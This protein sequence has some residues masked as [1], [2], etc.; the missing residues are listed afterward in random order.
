MQLSLN[1]RLSTQVAVKLA[2]ELP[3]PR[4]DQWAI[5]IAK[6]PTWN[7]SAALLQSDASPRMIHESKGS[8]S[9]V[10]IIMPELDA[11]H[12]LGALVPVVRRGHEAQWG[13]VLDLQ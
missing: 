6:K 12:M 10:P 1:A 8:G 3:D 5:Q 11:V 4:A 2:S 9:I 13:P 7:A